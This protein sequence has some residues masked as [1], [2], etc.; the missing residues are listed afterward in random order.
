VSELAATIHAAF[1]RLA[2]EKKLTYKVEVATAA[3]ESIVT[4]RKRLEQVIKNLVS[5]AIKFT[6]SGTVTVRFDRPAEEENLS[7]SGL[8]SEQAFAITVSDT[9]IGIATEQQGIIF[10]A[11]KQADGSTSRKYGGTGL[12][13]SICRELVHLLGGE[14]RLE[15]ASGRGSTFTVFLPVVLGNRAVPPKGREKI[16]QEVPHPEVGSEKPRKVQ[17][18]RDDRHRIAKADT[19]ILVVEDDERFAGVLRDKCHEKGFKCLAA[20]TGEEGLELASKYLPQGV[21]L[22]IRLPGMDGLAVLSE[23]KEDMR[24]RHI[25]VHIVSVEEA[26]T[27]ALRKGAVGYAS[28]P[29]SREDL[30]RAFLKIEQVSSKENRRVLVVE[31]NE[32]IRAGVVRLIRDKDVEVDEAATGEQAMDALRSREYG[33]MILDL[34]LPD[35]DG[36]EFLNR[37][38]QE[39]M[40][41]PPVIVHTARDLS[42]DQEMDLQEYTDSVVIKDVRSQERLLDE[43]S[44]FLHQQVN[45]MQGKKRQMIRSL[46]QTDELLKDKKVLVVDDDMRTVFALSRLLDERGM[47][48]LKAENGEKALRLLDQEGDVDLVLM[49][50]MMPVM[51]GYE[52]MRKIRESEKFRRLPVIALT[53]KAMKEDRERC[54]EAGANDY[55]PKPVDTQRLISMMRVWLYR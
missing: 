14:I 29:L 55:L 22:D 49:D 41:L 51:D 26:S 19:V 11:F 28:K 18:L 9:G 8:A 44:L 27:E 12:G 4:D 23:L 30:E 40:E 1:D 53:A 3:P 37:L 50:V 54:L 21:I 39:G 15:S 31:D 5:N 6:E 16:E 38:R 52:A 34:G 45:K 43:V 32:E 25:P 10:E 24:T 42:R 35:M 7:R 2:E 46:H 20:S 47:K 17:N 33:C 48:P 13:L 36:R